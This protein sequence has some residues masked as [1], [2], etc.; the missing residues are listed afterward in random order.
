MMSTFP[1]TPDH[2]L[3]P[4]SFPVFEADLSPWEWEE[5]PAPSFLFP[6]LHHDPV[7]KNITQ[8]VSGS[9]SDSSTENS[10]TNPGFSSS[11]SDDPNGNGDDDGPRSP[12]D[13]RKRRRKI[14]NR[15][16]ARRSRLRKQRQ[17][18]ELTLELNRLRAEN[19]KL[20]NQLRSSNQLCIAAQR[21]NELVRAQSSA[22]RQRLLGV[23]Q[24]LLLRQLQNQDN[25]LSYAHSVNGGMQ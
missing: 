25:Q 11:G 20:T 7:P 22:L 17:L 16:S 10:K 13:E 8:A 23:H 3:L 19:R 4:N 6:L 15:E 21:N 5:P 9:D 18:E 2:F 14:S 24:A 1:V 12:E